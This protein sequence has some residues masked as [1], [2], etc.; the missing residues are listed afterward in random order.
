VKE[1]AR[2]L[3]REWR[4]D[5][6][7]GLAAEVAF[8]GLLSVFPLL[9]AVA[10]ILGSLDSIVGTDLAEDA[11]T[12]VVGFF[13][14]LLTD[15]GDTVREGVEQL[16]TE[17][18]PGLVTTAVVAAVWSSS[19][20]LHALLDALQVVYD[21]EQRRGWLRRRLLAVGLSLA[22]VVIGA[23]LLAA[24]VAGP[25][26]GT[27]RDVADA[28]GAGEAFATAW[29]IA[30]YPTVAFVA[31]AWCATIMHL[32]R[33]HRTRWRHDVPGA[34]VA[35]AWGLAA[36]V[37]LR[38]YLDLAAETNPVLG[39]LGGTIVV[40]L[41]LYLVAI[42]VLVGGEVNNVVRLRWIEQRPMCAGPTEPSGSDTSVGD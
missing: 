41:W 13:S 35:G 21:L 7:G 12:E 6:I 17:R 11:R 32:A 19:R 33:Q 28:I 31:V 22:S 25:L 37:G 15:E 34:V 42:G 1:F 20:G 23:A 38:V 26:L 2:T 5:R 30:R 24:V 9:L 40:V 8:F 3:L 14:R 16:F 10:A 36:T 4:E 29:D 39:T 18:R 27:G